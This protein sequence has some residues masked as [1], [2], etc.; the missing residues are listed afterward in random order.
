MSFDHVIF[1]L[2]Y[3]NLTVDGTNSDVIFGCG[4]HT[5]MV[6]LI[7]DGEVVYTCWGELFAEDKTDPT[8]DCLQRKVVAQV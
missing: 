8:I 1:E 3:F 5:Y 7:E 2:S 6:E 4:E